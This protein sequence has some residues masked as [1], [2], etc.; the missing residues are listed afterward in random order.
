MAS[1]KGA[2]LTPGARTQLYPIDGQPQAL[3]QI[4]DKPE[5]VTGFDNKQARAVHRN[6]LADEAAQ[7]RRFTGAGGAPPHR[8]QIGNVLGEHQLRVP[9]QRAAPLGF[10]EDGS[11]YCLLSPVAPKPGSLEMDLLE[12]LQALG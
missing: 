5:A 4:A 9:V 3:G 2:R 10:V 7:G 8:G 12:W 1:A 6:Q 11:R